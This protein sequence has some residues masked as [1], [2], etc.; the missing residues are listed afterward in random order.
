MPS[1]FSVVM[2]K[3]QQT[4]QASRSILSAATPF[5]V[6]EISTYVVRATYSVG[7]FRSRDRIWPQTEDLTT[8]FHEGNLTHQSVPMDPICHPC[9]GS[10]YTGTINESRSGIILIRA[11]SIFREAVER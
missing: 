10:I 4:T 8:S 5:P 1:T 3:G 7:S 9:G 2:V 11:V 6:F